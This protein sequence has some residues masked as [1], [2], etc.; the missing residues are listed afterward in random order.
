MRV[1]ESDGSINHIPAVPC[2][3]FDVTGAGDTVVSAMAASL[4]CGLSFVD[5]GIVSTFAASVAVRKIGVAAVSVK[6]IEASLTAGFELTVEPR[7][8]I[9]EPQTAGA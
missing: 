7:R 5:A 8:L 6:E 3:V 9:A 1:F 4:S 2:E